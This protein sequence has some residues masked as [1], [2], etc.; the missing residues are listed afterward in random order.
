MA[1]P[2]KPAK[3]PDE[4]PLDQLENWLVDEMDKLKT[5]LDATLTDKMKIADRIIKVAMIKLKI[6]DDNES[7]GFDDD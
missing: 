5:S 2:K 1:A 7:S 4:S 3:K 6:T